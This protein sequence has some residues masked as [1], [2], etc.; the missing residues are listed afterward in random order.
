MAAMLQLVIPAYRSTQ[1]QLVFGPPLAVSTL[2]DSRTDQITEAV[3]VAMLRLLQEHYPT[4]K[5][6]IP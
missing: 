1:V 4:S 6:V 3:R 2:I 5:P